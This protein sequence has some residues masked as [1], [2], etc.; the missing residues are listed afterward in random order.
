LKDVDILN[1]EVFV[2]QMQSL[3]MPV[4][5]I[6]RREIPIKILPQMRDPTTGRF[7]SAGNSRSLAYPTEYILVFEK[8]AFSLASGGTE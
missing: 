8:L 5:R 6:I 7:A 4:H 3:G 2:E 1:S